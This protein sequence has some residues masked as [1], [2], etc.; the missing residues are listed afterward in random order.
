MFSLKSNTSKLCLLYLIAILIKNKFSLLD[1]QFYNP[2]LTQFGA[3]ELPNRNYI[4]L[5]KKGLKNKADF[6]DLRDFQEVLSI[7][8]SI[9]HKS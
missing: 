4:T 1:S 8:Q 9:N 5:L 3:F 2:H 7:I 6:K